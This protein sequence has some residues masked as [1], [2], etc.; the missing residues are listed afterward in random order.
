MFWYILTHNLVNYS[1]IQ[2][3][4]P[5]FSAFCMA[6]DISQEFLTLE[7]VS[8]SIIPYS[9]NPGMSLLISN[10]TWGIIHRTPDLVLLILKLIGPRIK[11]QIIV[12]EWWR[13]LVL[14]FPTLSV[15]PVNHKVCLD[16]H[17]TCA[18]GASNLP[19]KYDFLLIYR[20]FLGGRGSLLWCAF[21][22]QA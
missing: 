22:Y 10:I 20:A 18:F 21:R 4:P 8:S 14:H 17:P 15:C 7:F 13:C 1:F 3:L 16:I 11:F 5:S 9:A 6:W 2:C 19:Q 12:N